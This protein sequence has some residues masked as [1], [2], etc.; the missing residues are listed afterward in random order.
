MLHRTPFE[1]GRVRLTL[2]AVVLSSFFLAIGKFTECRA[3]CMS[4]ILSSKKQALHECCSKQKTS[5]TRCCSGDSRG[6]SEL[7]ACPVCISSSDIILAS[8][9]VEL[10]PSAPMGLD[11]APFVQATSRVFVTQ[12]AGLRHQIVASLHPPF[13]V[14]HCIWRK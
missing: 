10:M 13:R 8:R 7:P 3:N 9:T 11:F 6:L 1:A 12:T 4:S 2:V 14:L 5:S